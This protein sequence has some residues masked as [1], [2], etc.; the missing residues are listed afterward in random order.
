MIPSLTTL[1]LKGHLTTGTNLK[2]QL[3]TGTTISGTIVNGEASHKSYYTNSYE[4]TPTSEGFTLSTQEKIMSGN[5]V[6]NP[7]PY[8]EIE[9]EY[10]KTIQIG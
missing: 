6:V 8:E 2:G 10:G 3:T 9:N 1:Q 4:V 7:I 5:L